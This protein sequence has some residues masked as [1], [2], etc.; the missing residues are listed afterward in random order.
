MEIHPDDAARLGL[1]PLDLV[2][3]TG[4]TG[5]AVLQA[6]ITDAVAPGQLFAL[7]YHWSG[8]GNALT[9]SYTDPKTTIPWYKGA[10][11]GLRRVGPS[12]MDARPS[13]LQGVDRLS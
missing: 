13:P 7:Q 5:S 1:D 3:L 10:R 2:E 11:V 4:R 12:P 9:T 8:T 6:R